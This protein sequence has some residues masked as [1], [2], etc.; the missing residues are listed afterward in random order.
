MIINKALIKYGYSNFKLEILEYCDPKDI[1]KREQYFMDYL[2]PEYN[3][4]NLAYSSLG[5]KH[6]KETLVKVNKN[7]AN[8]NKKKSIKVKVTNMKTNVSHEYA[9]L[10]DAAKTLNTS[11]GTLKKYINDCSLFNGIYKLE[12]DLVES[13]YDSNY[14]N[15]PNAI[16]IEVTDLELKTKTTYTSFRAASRAL[17]INNFT[18]SAYFKRNQM[19]PY[20]GRYVFKKITSV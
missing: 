14:L 15:H 11:R 20:K 19:R 6:S 10:T 13:N 17:N 9:S 1:I 7:L 4:L 5:Y 12:A 3:V 8:I 16:K 18:I 2:K